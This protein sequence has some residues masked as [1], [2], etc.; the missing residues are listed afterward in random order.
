MLTVLG[1][2][3]CVHRRNGRVLSNYPA[4]RVKKHTLAV[5]AVDFGNDRAIAREQR[6]GRAPL[7]A[8]RQL[9]LGEA[10]G[11]TAALAL[12]TLPGLRISWIALPRSVA[13]TVRSSA[14]SGQSLELRNHP[15]A[16]ARP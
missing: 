7:G 8:D 15:D 3:E 12:R 10:V 9:A 4:D 11:A 2:G 13:T 6:L 16:Y 14:S 5:A 1:R